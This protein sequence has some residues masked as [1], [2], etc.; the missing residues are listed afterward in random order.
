LGRRSK[1][2]NG[3]SQA[4]LVIRQQLTLAVQFGEFLPQAEV[5][6]FDP[7]DGNTRGHR[8]D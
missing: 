8:Q 1:A 5:M 3:E 6:P 2:A 4:G 7:N